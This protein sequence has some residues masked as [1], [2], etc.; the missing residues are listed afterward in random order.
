[1]LEQGASWHVNGSCHAIFDLLSAKFHFDDSK[2]SG[3][4]SGEADIFEKLLLKL[5]ENLENVVDEHGETPLH[6]AVRFNLHKEALLILKMNPGLIDKCNPMEKTAIEI[7]LNNR[8]MFA[9]LVNYLCER[10][11]DDQSLKH[12]VGIMLKYCGGSGFIEILEQCPKIITLINEFPQL[13]DD[14]DILGSLIYR[15]LDKLNA[16][17]QRGLNLS[18]ILPSR[19]CSLL[20][21]VFNSPMFWVDTPWERDNLRRILEFPNAVIYKNNR[22]DKSTLHLK[23]ILENRD[24]EFL[25][26]FLRNRFIKDLNFQ[27]LDGMT[28]LHYAVLMKRSFWIKV[29]LDSGADLTIKDNRGYTAAQYAYAVGVEKCH[30]KFLKYKPNRS[31]YSIS[32]GQEPGID[33]LMFSHYASET[34]IARNKRAIAEA[35][36]RGDFYG[37]PADL[38]CFQRDVDDCLSKGNYPVGGFY[39]LEIEMVNVPCNVNPSV[40]RVFSFKETPDVS[41]RK[42]LLMTGVSGEFVSAPIGT[43][44][45]VKS[46]LSAANYLYEQGGA[47]NETAGLHVHANIKGNRKMGI[48]SIARQIT[49]PT[50]FEDKDLELMIVK[51]VL[52]NWCQL[53]QLLM[54]V[55]RFGSMWDEGVKYCQPISKDLGKYL[56]SRDI[57]SLVRVARG[58]YFAVNLQNLSANRHG[59]VEFRMHEGACHPIIIGA[60][61][62]FIHRLMNISVVQ[63]NNMLNQNNPNMTDTFLPHSDIEHLFYIFL[64]E[65]YYQYTWDAEQGHVRGAQPMAVAGADP[66][67]QKMQNSILYR[68]YQLG[69]EGK[70]YMPLLENCLPKE[71]AL[72]ERDVKTMLKV[73]EEY[74]GITT[75]LERFS[76]ESKTRLRARL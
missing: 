5:S 32:I 24:D 74:P 8:A 35:I 56:L 1:M 31:E 27:D 6:T 7:A 2:K 18:A 33:E 37:F 42:S 29:L 65:R 58:K 9:T 45:A 55:L 4:S 67:Q 16:M 68:A 14:A 64:A 53:E 43:S 54:A 52:V 38:S 62:N 48:P 46:V 51:Q 22:L 57:P 72:I 26:D 75:D 10:N 34:N 30:K 63:V 3:H 47:V 41:L 20:F 73:N 23:V 49:M 13:I 60:W 59:T 40:M 17:A 39:G 71:R 21:Y 28:P 50:I 61:L 69:L 25:I 19:R 15:S 11:I 44:H 76:P 66:I 12:A 36:D 70:E